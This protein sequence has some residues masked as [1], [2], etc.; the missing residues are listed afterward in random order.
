MQTAAAS[1]V[2]FP[3]S[4][5]LSCMMTSS[6]GAAAARNQEYAVRLYRRPLV[7][8]L[9]CDRR[10]VET[11]SRNDPDQALTAARAGPRSHSWCPRRPAPKRRPSCST[12]QP[13]VRHATQVCSAAPAHAACG[14]HERQTWLSTSA[15]L[16]G[17]KEGRKELRT[18]VCV[19]GQA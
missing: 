1:D 3:A 19:L 8:C 14:N 6:Y 10:A 15:S 9:L 5:R 17:R 13:A 2:Q 7:S 4:Q 12:F 16:K 11:E 18:E